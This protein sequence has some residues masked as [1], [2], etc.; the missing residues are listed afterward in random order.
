MKQGKFEARRKDPEKPRQSPEQAESGKKRK[1]LL[2]LAP[3][4]ALVVIGAA[5]T[6]GILL[7]NRQAPQEP[8]GL[9]KEETLAFFQKL[10]A[11]IENKI[12]RAHV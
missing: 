5:V 2:I 8:E 3:I 11:E 10:A 7:Q 6:A 9:T 1:W 12:G 4:L